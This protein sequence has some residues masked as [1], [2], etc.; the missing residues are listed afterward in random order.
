[1]FLY[2]YLLYKNRAQFVFLHCYLII[3]VQTM[4]YIYAL[5]TLQNYEI[6]TYTSAYNSTSWN[7]PKFQFQNELRRS[8]ELRWKR[9][10]PRCGTGTVSKIYFLGAHSSL[11][12]RDYHCFSKLWMTIITFK[13]A[14]VKFLFDWFEM[15]YIKESGT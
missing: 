2:G 4:L 12:Q 10:D 11:L 6:R 15:Y 9:Y 13:L 1:M 5:K 3:I 8:P 7:Y 14:S